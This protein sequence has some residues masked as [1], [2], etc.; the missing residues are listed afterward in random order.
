MSANER[1]DSADSDALVSETGA[2]LT[3]PEAAR[4]YAWALNDPDPYRRGFARGL[5]AAA[6]CPTTPAVPKGQSDG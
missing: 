4:Y 1:P 6:A 3:V 2:P 5:A